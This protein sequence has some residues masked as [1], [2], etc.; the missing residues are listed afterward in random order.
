MNPVNKL[1]SDNKIQL[2]LLSDCCYSGK[3]VRKLNKKKY[4]VQG[5]V[6]LTYYSSCDEDEL[7]TEHVFS[8]LFK[9]KDVVPDL[10]G[11]G[12]FSVLRDLVDREI[13]G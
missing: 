1:T 12:D 4:K 11:G 10:A 7:A 8:S 2:L 6:S 13:G 5:E 9:E 3:W